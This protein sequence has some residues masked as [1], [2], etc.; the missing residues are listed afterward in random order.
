MDESFCNLP[1]D[2]YGGTKAASEAYILGFRQYANG[3]KTV[4]MKRNIIRPGYTYSNPPYAG[5]K[6]QLDSRFRDIASAA[7]HNEP[8][9]VTKHD[10]TQ[11]LSAGEIAQVYLK[12][13]ESDKNEEI[14]LALGNVFTTWERIAEMTLEEYPQ[15]TSPIIA[16]DKG[17]DDQTDKPLSYD[18]DKIKRDFGLSFD[19]QAEL[20][21]HVRWNL[22]QALI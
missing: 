21:T 17:W 11:F 8:I 4:T 16:E 10:G 5:G 22:A 2:I 19:S 18:V 20:R 13:L 9:K 14:Y 6:T 1:L 12:L 7:V 3:G 15:S